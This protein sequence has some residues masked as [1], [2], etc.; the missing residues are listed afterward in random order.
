[1]TVTVHHQQETAAVGGVVE[2]GL[3]APLDGGRALG[4]GL[5]ISLKN[6]IGL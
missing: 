4:A 2:A 6:W 1:M 5:Q 3:A